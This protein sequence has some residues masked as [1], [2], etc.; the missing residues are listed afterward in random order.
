ML[1]EDLHADRALP[2]D[3]VRIVERMHEREVVLVHQT[4]SVFVCLAVGL[5]VQTISTPRAATAST[6][7]VGRGRRHDDDGATSEFVRRERDALRMV[8]RRGGDDATGALL[9][10]ESGHLVVRAA[11]LEGEDLLQILALEE[12]AVVE[13]TGQVGRDLERRL[14]RNVVHVG[15]ENAREIVDR[16]VVERWIA[17]R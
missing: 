6:L 14:D 10:G 1:T 9:I 2:G 12:H 3:H 7:S 13:P 5:A 4:L 11:E 8:A 17:G 15:V 16:L